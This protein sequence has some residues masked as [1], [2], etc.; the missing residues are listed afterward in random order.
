MRVAAER[1][2]GDSALLV[3]PV[4]PASDRFLI[5][6]A[7]AGDE[8]A[9]RELVERYEPRV[10]ATVV[11]ML[12]AGDEAEDV[13]QETFIRLYRSLDRFRGDSSLGTYLTR[14]AINLSLTALKRRKRRTSRFVS[15]DE[16]ERELPE[17]SVDPRGDLERKE[18]AL[19]V[20]AAVE[21]L[22]P[23]HRAVVVLRMI[24]GLSTR[25]TAEILGIPAGTVMSRLARAMDR[26]ERALKEPNDE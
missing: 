11:G 24:D 20:R 12:G 21:A 15:R 14:I 26:L 5:D 1:R 8:R 3:E 9:F 4:E 2:F 13:G 10:A 23:D 25:E 17:T 19:E 16:R 22:A 7:R 18:T 6:R